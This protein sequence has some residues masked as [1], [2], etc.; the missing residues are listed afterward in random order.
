MTLTPARERIGATVCRRLS[1]ILLALL[2]AFAGGLVAVGR[3]ADRPRRDRPNVLFIAVDDMRAELG[4][5]GSPIVKSPNLD[6]LAARS[7]LFERAY[8]Q[9][10][11]CNPSRASVLTG[12]RIDSLGFTDLLT[13]FRERRPDVV[14]L[15]Q[16]FKQA[17]YET[18]GIGKIFH[19]YRQDEWKGDPASWSRPQQLHYGNHGHDVAQVEGERPADAVAI[20]RAE[21]REVPDEA[22]W[23]GQIAKLAVDR[24]NEIKDEPFFLAVGFWKP[25]LPFNAP[26]KYWAMYDPAEIA[27]PTNPE[28]PTGVPSIAL[29]DGREI[30]RDFP[31]GL[32]PDDVRTLRHGYYAAISY[33]DAQIGKVLDELARLDLRDET[34]VV[35][36]SDHGFHLGEHDLWCKTSN[37]ELDARVPLMISVPGQST[38]GRRT[39]SLVELL[40][41]YPTIADYSRLTPPSGLEGHSL[42]PLFEDPAATVREVAFTQHPRP[43]YPKAGVA[44]EAMGYSLRSDRFRYTEWRDFQT[45]RVVA[46]ELYDH[47]DDPRETINRAD[48]PAWAPT[49]AAF[50]ERLDEF[51]D[52][53]AHHRDR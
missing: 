53:K 27:P 44:P 4:C 9:Q 32:T 28:P 8:C 17:G 20:P 3:A 10:A 52:L 36:W 19:N 22:Y 31:A 41:I 24:L 23:D 38:A 48:E 26:E 16:L 5:Y 11:L 7:L 13:H 42:R 1:P 6:A 15:P 21:R 33:V 43:G 45:G 29:H 2:V 49:V 12:L 47:R 50:R 30:M 25:H 34:I 37:F 39:Q 14:T 18:H 51:A 46:T 40:D 35:F